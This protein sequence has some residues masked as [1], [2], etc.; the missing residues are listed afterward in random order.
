M[1][2]RSPAAHAVAGLVFR[3]Y[4]G[5][6]D[7]PVLTEVLRAAN[8]F[9]DTE[10]V[11]S[12]ARVANDFAH[13]DGFDPTIDAFLGELNGR[14]VAVGDVRYIRRDDTHTYMVSGAVHP[15]ER[16]RGIGRAL[17]GVLEGRAAERVE[18]LPDA[19]PV[20]IDAWM[21]DANVGFGVL[22]RDAGYEPTRHFFEMLKTDLDT[23]AEV[24]L[25]E[26]LELRPVVMSDM[27]RIFDAEAE[28]F[29]DHWG[30]RDWSDEVFAEH[31]AD[32]DLD[33]TLWR[34]AWDGD[35][36]AGVVSTFIIADENA[37]LGVQRGWL[38][39][40]SVRRPWRRRGLAAALIVSA[41]VGL[42]ERGM[43]EAAL[44]VDA[45]N[46]TGAL[47]LYE[48][49]GFVVRRRATSWRRPLRPAPTTT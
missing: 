49:L 17:L 27:R 10:E 3:R 18:T 19:A 33:P 42:R 16:R 30:R 43:H 45:E 12:E 7:I 6:S 28:A 11:P 35:E 20:W 26:G 37:A 25:P 13:P 15:D 9:D 21:P 40:V 44:G 31:L 41:C 47:G 46:L 22:I 2:T 4:A 38:A 39:H 1:I 32:P 14:V 23:A 8:L 5:P 36:V 48:R 34:V 29:Q 24:T